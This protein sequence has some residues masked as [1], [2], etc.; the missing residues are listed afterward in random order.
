MATPSGPF[1]TVKAALGRPFCLRYHIIFRQIA[2]CGH[3]LATFALCLKVSCRQ[4]RHIEK[5]ARVG[6]GIE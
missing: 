1:Q 6:T 4:Q 3:K 5:I 2:I